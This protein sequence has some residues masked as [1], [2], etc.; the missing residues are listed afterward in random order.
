LLLYIQ[1]EQR[2]G[3][4]A[5]I[6]ETDILYLYSQI[7]SC[8]SYEE[9]MSLGEIAYMEENIFMEHAETDVNFEDVNCNIAFGWHLLRDIL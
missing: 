1:R 9:E 4:L 8:K 7:Y 3:Y 5:N 2:T 6:G